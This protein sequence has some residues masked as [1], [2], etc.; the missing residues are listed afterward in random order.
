MNKKHQ[1]YGLMKSLKTPADAWTS[2]ALDFIV[3]LPKSKEPI[4]KVV[5]NSIL[6]ITD[7]LTKYGY[8]IPYKK[9]SLAEDLA[10]TFYRYVVRNNGLLE[11]IISDWDKL[12]IFKFWKSLMDLVGTKH[13]LLMSYHP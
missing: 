1:P 6:V 7:R 4:T 9:A 5:Y 3:K 11:E 2:V 8:F 13:N 12:F 10:Y